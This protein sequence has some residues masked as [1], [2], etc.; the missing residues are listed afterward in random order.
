MDTLEGLLKKKVGIYRW[1]E[2]YYVW[3]GHKLSYWKQKED[4]TQGKEAKGFYP[5][6]Q[7]LKVVPEDSENFKLELKEKTLQLRGAE[8]EKWVQVL[9]KVSSKEDHKEHDNDDEDTVNWSTEQIL[10]MMGTG[11]VMTAYFSN[12]TKKN[13]K[14]FCKEY[15]LHACPSQAGIDKAII[16]LPLRRIS[17][18]Y[19]GKQTPGF[20]TEVAAPVSF[21]RCFTVISRKYTLDVEAKS[22]QM[23]THWLS[24][25]K[26]LLTKSGK[27]VIVNE[28]EG[29]QPANDEHPTE[30]GLGDQEPAEEAREEPAEESRQEHPESAH[31]AEQQAVAAVEAATKVS[32]ESGAGHDLD[33]GEMDD[34]KSKSA[35]LVIDVQNDFC[36]PTGSLAVKDGLAVIPVI[37]KLRKRV[38]WGLIALSQD[39]HP[40]SHMSFYVNNKEKPGAALYKPLDLG[41]GKSQVMWPAHCVQ[42]SNELYFIGF[43]C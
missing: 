6:D 14:L 3:D 25:I 31:D 30:G 41:D 21:D 8:A 5:A 27:A 18:I 28:S 37:N 11:Q 4:K 15:T 34:K 19:V 32:P 36:P 16:S 43:D 40:E 20:D 7:I 23:A 26:Y 29:A 9:K 1:A 2:R 33:L 22:A 24:G 13:F 12:N 42:D 38:K 39:W 17:D 10:E 35:L